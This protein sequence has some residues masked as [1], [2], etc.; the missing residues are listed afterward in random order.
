MKVVN[1]HQFLLVQRYDRKIVSPGRVERM[2][3]EDFCQAL[4]IYPT[5]KYEARGG[6]S[7][8][9]L[10]STIDAHV[11]RRGC[12]RLALLDLI[13]FS[14]CIGDTDRHGKNY[15]LVL[16]HGGPRLAPGY[17]LVSALAY[18]GITRNLAMK[19]AGKNR[20][21]HLE[22]RHWERFAVDVGLSPAATVHKVEEVAS[23]A[24]ERAVEVKNELIEKYPVNRDAV[25]LFATKIQERAQCVGKNSR[26]NST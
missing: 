9:D 22:R 25:E 21:E 7:L 16:S 12:D 17:D 4:G 1:G 13:I 20:A 14:C 24:T 6:P 8:V 19:I 18:D 11:Q 5:K 10:Y 2:H 3:Q 23:L 15:S 26:K